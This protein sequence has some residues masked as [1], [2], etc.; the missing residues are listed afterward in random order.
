MK[1]RI[2]NLKE[3]CLFCKINHSLLLAQMALSLKIPHSPLNMALCS[4]LI[5]ILRA[6]I[7]DLEIPRCP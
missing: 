2:T 3:K 4:S 5:P 7:Y 1:K 6:T